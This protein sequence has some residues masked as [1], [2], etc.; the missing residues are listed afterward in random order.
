MAEWTLQDSID[1]YNIDAWGAGYFRVGPTGNVEVTPDGPGGPSLDL[2]V[3]VNQLEERGLGLPILLR[4]P[5]IIRN[6]VERL[7]N[8]FEHAIDEENYGGKYHAVY[9]VKVNQQRRVIETLLSMTDRHSLGLEAGSKPEVL[10][11]LALADHPDALLILNG[12]KDQEFV[13]TSLLA[14]KLGRN[15]IIVVD[16]YRELEVIL[17]AAAKLD[18]QP[19]IGVRAQLDARAQGKWTESSGMGSKFGLD[20]EELV[21]VVDLLRNRNMLDALVLLHFHVGSQITGIR[22]VK[23]AVQEAARVYVELSML[24]AS[25]KY[26]DVGGGLGVDYDGTQSTNDSSMNYDLQEYANN[27]I[28]HV[29]EMCDEKDVP[30]PDIISESGR[31]LVAHHSALIINVPDIDEGLPKTVPTPVGD[32]EHRVLHSLYGTWQDIGSENVLESWHDA[33]FAREEAITLF[34]SG[35]LDLKERARADTLYRACCSKILQELRSFEEIPEELATLE[36]RFCDIYFGNFSMFQSAPDHWAVDQLFPI[37]PIH[38]LREEP[39]RRGVVADLTCDSDGLIDRFIGSEEKS[40]IELHA[41]DGSPYYLGVFLL[42]A[43]QEILGDLHNL[44]GDTNAVHV[45]I[46]P[47]GKVRLDDVVEHDS[48][49]DVLGYVGFERKDLLARIRRAVERALDAGT[50]TLKESALFLRDFENGL[51]G[52]TYLEEE[53]VESPVHST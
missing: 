22:G 36:R 7:C 51:T 2:H 31:A 32:D 39:T 11:A 15:A 9:P 52:T 48:V 17:K 35:V 42:G 44:F 33:N 50:L 41:P 47:D 1:L 25:L 13:E 23:D 21:D 20:P 45:L 26:L 14:R 30:H 34:A 3:F 28:F 46:D 49:A 43:Y 10:A 4:F 12:Y 24:G 40:V 18:V 16:R 6:R 29:R 8:A 27:V 37:M 19:R 53:R 38:R 5:G